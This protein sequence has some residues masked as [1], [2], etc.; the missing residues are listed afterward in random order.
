[1]YP[2]DEY[3]LYYRCA[4]CS[5]LQISTI[6]T[7][8]QSFYPSSY[9]PFS[10][11]TQSLLTRNKLFFALLSKLPHQLALVFT[12]LF[13]P[14]QVVSFVSSTKLPRHSS[15]LEVGCGSASGFLSLFKLGFKNLTGTDAFID[16]Q[17]LKKLPFPAYSATLPPDSRLYDLIILNHVFE[18]VEDPF[19]LLSQL[20]LLL[21]HDGVLCILSPVANSLA[22]HIFDSR[23][24]QLD[25]PRHLNIPSTTGLDKLASLIG[26][27]V[28][29][30]IFNSSSFQF[31]GSVQALCGVSLLSANSIY[32]GTPLSKMILALLSPVLALISYLLNLIGRGDQAAFILKRN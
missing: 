17:Y 9:S 2:S 8:L 5:S 3:F 24:I 7:N 19:S 28:V 22:S 1:M 15:I 6:P 13:N 23:W 27:R 25:P 11:P 31:I 29:S 26:L 16:P 20:K 10:S 18:H 12:T 32:N 4:S 30:T 14:D 21:A